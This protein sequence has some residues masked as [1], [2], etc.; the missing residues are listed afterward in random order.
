MAKRTDEHKQFGQDGV[1]NR[2]DPVSG[3]NGTRPNRLLSAYLHTDFAI[4]FCG[5][6]L[7]QMSCER[8]W[9]IAYVFCVIDLV[10]NP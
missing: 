3:A 10:V 9:R 4:L 7:G 5:L 6:S 2:P 1:R 8:G